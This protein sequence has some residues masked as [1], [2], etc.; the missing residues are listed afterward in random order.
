MI[1]SY[2][3][4]RALLVGN[5]VNLLNSNQSFSWGDLLQELKINS[6]IDVDLD[7]VFKPFPLAFD[8]MLHHKGGL[9]D[10]NEN[11]KTLKQKISQN[12]KNQLDGKSGSNRYHKALMSLP[13][14][15][16][17]TTNYDYSLQ[18]S[19]APDFLTHK[20]KLAVNKQEMK[21]SL[22]RSYFIFSKTIWHMHGELF[23]S[24]SHSKL[25]KNYKEES[26]MIGYEHYTSYLEKIQENVRGKSGRQKGDDQSLMI[27]LRDNVSSPYWTDI[28]FTHNL[29]IVGQGFD[30]SENHLWWLINGVCQTSCRD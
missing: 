7:N 26:I 10:F 18:T 9:N 19:I 13:Y 30:Y 24:R 3:N 20:N 28:F 22:K 16:I 8:E 29:D 11:I 25:S 12:I 2:R 27:R 15:D 17:L 14:D 21:H 23:D 6:D 1:E 4:K 5:G